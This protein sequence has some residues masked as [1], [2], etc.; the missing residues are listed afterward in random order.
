MMMMMGGCARS[1]P[2]FRAIES[3]KQI[4]FSFNDLSLGYS[5]REKVTTLLDTRTHTPSQP[6]KRHQTLPTPH[7]FSNRFQRHR[8]PVQDSRKSALGEVP[9]LQIGTTGI[10]VVSSS[11]RDPFVNG[12]RCSLDS[13]HSTC[14]CDQS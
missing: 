14:D 1:D 9:F 10:S 8:I 13:Q 2:I 7:S 4:Q 3:E 11:A 12:T 5:D 6:S